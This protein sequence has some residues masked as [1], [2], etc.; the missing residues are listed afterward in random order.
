MKINLKLTTSFWN[1]PQFFE[2]EI[3]IKPMRFEQFSFG[4]FIKMYRPHFMD[5]I[6]F[7]EWTVKLTFRRFPGISN[8][9]PLYTTTPK[10]PWQVFCFKLIWS[11]DNSIW[12]YLRKKWINSSS[13]KIFVNKFPSS[14]PLS[15]CFFA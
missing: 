6:K 10:S 2:N 12:N 14:S 3:E 4:L 13:A 1:F 9:Q 15:R 5:S 11:K 7:L 8:C